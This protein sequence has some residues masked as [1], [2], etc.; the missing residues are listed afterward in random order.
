MN[1]ILTNVCAVLDDFAQSILNTNNENRTF[2]EF[3]NWTCPPLTRIDLA[4]IVFD[5]SNKIKFSNIEQ[6]EADLSER[7]NEI[8][9]R[10]NLFKVH[11]QPQLFN[12]NAPAAIT[13]FMGMIIWINALIQPLFDWEIL[14]EKGALPKE[15]TRKLRSIRDDLNSISPEKEK[16]EDQIKTIKDA[17][18]TAESLPTDLQSLREARAKISTISSD[19][20][21][22]YGKIDKF[23]ADVE[24]SV[25]SIIEKENIASKLVSQCE[26]A[27]K[28]TTTKGLAAAFELRARNLTNTVWGWVGGLLVALVAGAWIGSSRFNI[29][30]HSLA[31]PNPHWGII[32]MQFSLSVI[33]FAAPLWLAWLATKQIGQRF[34][35][36]EDYAFKASVAKAYE[37]YRKEAARIDPK[38]E[39]RLFSSA[40]SRLEEAPLRLVESEHH[41]SPY[42]EF[43][44]SPRFQKAMSAFPELKDDFLKL[45][46]GFIGKGKGKVNGVAQN[47]D[48]KE[49]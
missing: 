10:V 12:S 37:G 40:L 43:F 29:L 14:Q 34:R 44:N 18:E 25:K 36:A 47:I 41:S 46:S 7:L 2:T 20:S 23:H 3:V 27:Y 5:I 6:V 15:L 13:A 45:I 26:E 11:T 28:I 42:Q 19:S 32:W 21:A 30:S 4:N 35:L 8:E 31:A 1:N 38:F 39:A 49:E 17:Y 22:L 33:S 48:D 9:N 16:L 24:V